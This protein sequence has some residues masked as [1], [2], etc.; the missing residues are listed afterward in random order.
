M[1][2][3]TKYLLKTVPAIHHS[4]I[5]ND[6]IVIAAKTQQET[7]NSILLSTRKEVI[8]NYAMLLYA[9]SWTE[10]M[11]EKYQEIVQGKDDVCFRTTLFQFHETLIANYERRTSG[12]QY[13]VARPALT[14]SQ[15]ESR[16]G[17]I[18]CQS[19]LGHTSLCG[20]PAILLIS[21]AV[22]SLCLDVA[23]RLEDSLNF[24]FFLE[25]A[26]FL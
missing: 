13:V 1:V 6:P 22:A 25:F 21:H 10:Y 12:N 3:W 24:F 11:D 19:H 18:A 26:S 4:Y 9:L 20:S 23:T 16:G 14:T 8:V 7:I 17:Q 15:E 2:N 5:I